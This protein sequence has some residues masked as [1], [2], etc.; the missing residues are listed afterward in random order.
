MTAQGGLDHVGHDEPGRAVHLLQ[1]LDRGAQV[2]LPLV[3]QVE[4]V[5]FLE[6]AVQH[7]LDAIGGRAGIGKDGHH[8]RQFGNR[9]HADFVP[10][11]ER[12]PQRGK[13]LFGRLVAGVFQHAGEEQMLQHRALRGR[14]CGLVVLF[15]DLVD[16]A[17]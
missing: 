15:Q 3:F 14:R 2:L 13:G 10:V 16:L 12:V 5:E 7:A 4:A 11:V 9:S 6:N 1:P 17:K 8:L